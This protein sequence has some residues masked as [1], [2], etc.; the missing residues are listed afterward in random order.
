MLTVGDLSHDEV[1]GLL[2]DKQGR[3]SKDME[4]IYGLVGGRILL[5]EAVTRKIDKGVG[6]AGVIS[7]LH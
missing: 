2:C 3:S 7:I 1:K 6:W 5:I 4:D